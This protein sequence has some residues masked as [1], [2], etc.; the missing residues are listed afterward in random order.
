MTAQGPDVVVVGSINHDL[1][2]RLDRTPHR[3]ET[4]LGD[5]ARWTPGGKGAN[6]AVGCA[7]LGLDVAM[8]GAV[9]T[10]ASGEELAAVLSSEGVATDDLARVEAPTGLAV[11]LVERSGESTI[12]VSPGANAQVSAPA[13]EAAARTVASAR[14]VL[15]QLEI[16]IDAVQRAVE[17]A[18]GLVVLNP[19]PGRALPEALLTEVDVLVPNRFELAEL[20]GAEVP[21][22]LEQVAAT[23]RGLRGPDAVVVTLGE[24]GAL[25]IDGGCATH[26]PAVAVSAVDTTGAGDGFCAAL[27]AGL[28]H[29]GDL[30]AATRDAV[31]IAAVT[32]LRRGA[33]SSLPR[34]DEVEV[35]LSEAGDP[36]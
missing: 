5:D 2:I 7:R 32:T 4:V 3:G 33:L 25:V 30:L 27:V 1:G 31:R 20:V 36:P 13:V 12:V 15:C 6:Q 18:E 11:V 16:P 8:V 28:L 24:Q 14:A 21:T 34:R 22:T 23:A 9:G 19:A 29:G 35:A 17:L 26:V 10:D